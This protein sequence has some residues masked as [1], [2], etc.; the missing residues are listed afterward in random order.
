MYTVNN[1]KYQNFLLEII[2]FIVLQLCF[3]SIIRHLYVFRKAAISIELLFEFSWL[4]FSLSTILI[5]LFGFI[6]MTNKMKGFLYIQSS[7]ILVFF[8][9]PSAILFANVKNIDSRIFLSHILFLSIVLFIG[10]IKL[11]VFSRTFNIYQ[12]KKILF[13]LIIVGLIPFLILYTPHLNIKNLI[14]EEIYETRE[15]LSMQVNNFYT[16]Y[17]YSWFNKVLIPILLVFGLYFKDKILIIFCSLSLVFLFLCGAHKAVFI[18]LIMV[19]VLYKFDYLKKTNYFIKILL[20]ISFVSFLLSIIFNN[21]LFATITIRRALFLPALLD[22]LYFDF[23]DNNFLLWSENFN[24]L[25]KAYTYDYSHSYVIGERYF[26]DQEWGANNGIISEGFMNFGI[27]GVIINAIIVGFY[28]SFIN[29]LNISSKFYGVFFLLFFSLISSS[30]P[31]VLL[32][33]G[34]FVLLLLS[35]FILKGTDKKMEQF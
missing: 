11:K 13:Y 18:G 2:L 25:L 30:L 31:T 19:L 21:D 14:L 12:S 23:F 28:F 20:I 10:K 26:L 6:I 32:S 17:S 22:V 35:F 3:T 29:Q 34:G 8:I 27:Y 24:G 33:H 9:F 7:L 15:L 16:N 1:I 5:F 4:K